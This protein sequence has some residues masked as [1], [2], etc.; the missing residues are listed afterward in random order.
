MAHASSSSE[1]SD[2]YCYRMD[3]IGCLDTCT[4]MYRR[5]YLTMKHRF[6]KQ[7]IGSRS[8]LQ[9]RL[10]GE[11]RAGEFIIFLCHPSISVTIHGFEWM[12]AIRLPERASACWVQGRDSGEGRNVSLAH[13][14]PLSTPGVSVSSRL[15]TSHS[16]L[17]PS[18]PRS[19]DLTVRNNIKMNV[20]FISKCCL[21]RHHL[22]SPAHAC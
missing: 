3:S 1:R 2:L 14:P 16:D 8:L 17:F 15:L 22:F 20:H 12:P 7:T 4:F 9:G 10:V 11:S 21:G 18:D 5:V 6:Q 19:Q 13:N